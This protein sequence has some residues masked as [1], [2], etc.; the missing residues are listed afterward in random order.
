MTDAPVVEAPSSRRGRRAAASVESEPVLSRRERRA[1]E[2]AAA[3]HEPAIAA[4]GPVR[5]PPLPEEPASRRPRQP[6]PV[7]EA[8]LAPLPVPVMAAPVPV[9]I[10]VPT[11]AAP[12]TDVVVHVPVPEASD[13]SLWPVRSKASW[14]RPLEES[15]LSTI[16]VEAVLESPVTSFRR[17]NAKGPKPV[18]VT[19]ATASG[20]QYRSVPVLV[21]ALLITFI[22]G[23]LVLFAMS[24]DWTSS[25]TDSEVPQGQAAGQTVTIQRALTSA[26]TPAPAPT[27]A[28]ATPAPTESAPPVAPAAPDP[29]RT[30]GSPI[31]VSPMLIGAGIGGLS[32]SLIAM[33][34]LLIHRLL[35]RRSA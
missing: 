15:E 33:V 18:R 30:A 22:A 27:T 21:H 11:P 31:E 16:D 28:A 4:P 35:G 14:G 10:P 29:S 6:V 17:K 7:A 1:A 19:R 32:L 26:A 8:P 2:A 5:L 34:G 12:S 20:R 25:R 24:L 23:A 9:A 3:A 13:E